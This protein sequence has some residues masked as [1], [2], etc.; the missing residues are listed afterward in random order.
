MD[1]SNKPFTF[2]NNE[3]DQ[4]TMGTMGTMGMG[5]PATDMFGN[6][7]GQMPSSAPTWSPEQKDDDDEL[8]EEEFLSE[9][10]DKLEKGQRVNFTQEEDS[11]E[12]VIENIDEDVV[13]IRMDDGSVVLLDLE[14]EDSSIKVLEEIRP[15]SPEYSP[16]G[17]PQEFRPT[18]PEY[19]PTG[20]QQGGETSDSDSE[21]DEEEKP[22]II[23]HH[24]EHDASFISISPI[25]F[26]L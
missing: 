3:W 23:I 7:M 12:G 14:D 5:I 24:Q 1:Y 8:M 26:F 9:T 17:P 21:E 19:S 6:V 11:G 13:M 4:A 15:T 18:S 22:P 25:Y 10:S 2:D 20:P 16:T